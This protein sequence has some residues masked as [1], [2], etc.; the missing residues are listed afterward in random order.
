MVLTALI[1]VV[2]L[3]AVGCVCVVWAARGGPKGARAVAAVTLTAGE[4]VRAGARA[5][6]RSNSRNGNDVG[7]MGCGND[8]C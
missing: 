3:A 2:A 7:T 8:G 5:N 4:L 1:G 6:G